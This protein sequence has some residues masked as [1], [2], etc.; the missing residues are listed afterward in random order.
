MVPA[1]HISGRRGKVRFDAA[2]P[3]LGSASGALAR[4]LRRP[5]RMLGPFVFEVTPWI[6]R[7]AELA[8]S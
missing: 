6:Q 7:L 1:V 5:E 2:R 4:F 3:V 8:C